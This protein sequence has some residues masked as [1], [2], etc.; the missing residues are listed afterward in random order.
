MEVVK[1]TGKKRS[2]VLKRLH[3]LESADIIECKTD[4]ERRYYWRVK[5]IPEKPNAP[6]LWI[7]SKSIY[8]INKEKKC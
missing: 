6:K 5:D 8:D 7:E 1:L 4:E 2:S 3:K